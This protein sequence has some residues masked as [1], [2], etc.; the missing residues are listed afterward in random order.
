M[1]DELQIDF[2]NYARTFSSLFIYCNHEIYFMKLDT[3]EV[4]TRYITDDESE[5]IKITSLTNLGRKIP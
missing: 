3:K 4:F 2:S 1:A 5:K